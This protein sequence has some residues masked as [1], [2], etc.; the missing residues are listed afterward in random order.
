[1]TENKKK[2]KKNN[3]V[4]ELWHS[5]NINMNNIRNLVQISRNDNKTIE[6]EL[7]AK[8]ITRWITSFQIVLC[9]REILSFKTFFIN[10]F[11]HKVRETMIS[12]KLFTLIN[13]PNLLPWLCIHAFTVQCTVGEILSFVSLRQRVILDD[14][15][16][17]DYLCVCLCVCMSE[18]LCTNQMAKKRGN[19]K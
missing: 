9:E 8:L 19:Q 14:F 2:E 15:F 6:K 10:S 16:C 11:A 1:M 5:N 3:N 17:W 18:L 12:R 13:T 4:N 7:Q